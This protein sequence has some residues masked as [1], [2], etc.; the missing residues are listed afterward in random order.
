MSFCQSQPHSLFLRTGWEQ[1]GLTFPFCPCQGVCLTIQHGNEHSGPRLLRLVPSGSWEASVGS[2][3]SFSL[4]D[5]PLAFPG[6]AISTPGPRRRGQEAGDSAIEL[7][8]V[9]GRG[10]W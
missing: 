4:I 6:H 5:L 10:W 8:P 3:G 7:C 2:P 9:R 1:G